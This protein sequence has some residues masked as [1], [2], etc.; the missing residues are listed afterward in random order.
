VRVALQ[1]C[2]DLRFGKTSREEHS[3]CHRSRGV[4]AR[5]IPFAHRPLVELP[6]LEQCFDADHRQTSSFAS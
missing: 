4:S 2:G 3:A 1:R 6:L 5:Y